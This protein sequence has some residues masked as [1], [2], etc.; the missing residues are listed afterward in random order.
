ME[1]RFERYDQYPHAGDDGR[2][3]YGSHF[4]QKGETDRY[5][6]KAVFDWLNRDGEK[7]S[8]VLTIIKP[9][10]WTL[11]EKRRRWGVQRNEKNSQ[12]SYFDTLK[13]A[14]LW[15]EERVGYFV[16]TQVQHKECPFP[17]EGN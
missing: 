1:L 3:E 15:V 17:R 6:Y 2:G 4:P 10:Y 16:L 8:I 7:R 5:A 9:G 14:K 13:E 11:P 12:Q